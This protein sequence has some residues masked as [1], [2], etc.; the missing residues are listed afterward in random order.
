MSEKAGGHKGYAIWRNYER[1]EELL[2]RKIIPMIP[3]N[4][5]KLVDQID[6]SLTSVGANFIEGYYSGST[7]EFIRF[8]RYS[9]RSLA[10]VEYWTKY[11]FNKRFVPE[12][13]FKQAESL[14]ARTGYLIDRLIFS[15]S[16]KL[17]PS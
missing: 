1:L 14:F 8:S 3:R 10:E 15:L 4:R 17:K 6:R 9:R 7:R 16:C 11:C 12:S 2:L 13:L 5:Y